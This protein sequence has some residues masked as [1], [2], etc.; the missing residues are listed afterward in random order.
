MKDEGSSRLAGGLARCCP[1]A[2]GHDPY[3]VISTSVGS[4]HCFC[5]GTE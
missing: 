3:R 1:A 4:A 2:A 5:S